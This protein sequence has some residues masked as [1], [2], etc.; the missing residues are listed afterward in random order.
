M[1]RLKPPRIVGVSGGVGTT[2]LATALRGCDRG[3]ALDQGVDVLVCRATGDSL[4]AA[5]AA[6]SWLANAGR[7]RPALAVTSDSPVPVRGVPRVRLQQMHPWFAGL[8]VLP[9]VILWREF[10]DPLRHVAQLAAYPV[11]ELP[12]QLR[13]YAAALERLT[14]VLLSSGL[15]YPNPRVT[16]ASTGAP[17][18]AFEDPGGVPLGRSLVAAR[19]RRSLIGGHGR[20]RTAEGRR[21]M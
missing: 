8:V 14:E 12:R 19:A 20:A 17:A 11:P 15:L 16:S 21:A 7:P 2:T 18:L 4:H 10:T 9:H 13:G 6:T 5:A 1:I 3:R